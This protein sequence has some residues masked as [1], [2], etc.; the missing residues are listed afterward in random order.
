[1]SLKLVVLSVFC[2]ILVMPAIGYG[3]H[4]TPFHDGDVAP[5]FSVTNLDNETVKLSDWRG[6][7]VM[8]DLWATWCSPCIGAVGVMESEIWQVYKDR[9]VVVWGVD[10]SPER[11]DIDKLKQFREDH[12]LTYP[13]AL[14]VDHETRPYASGYVPTL[15]IIDREGI[16]RFGEVGFGKDAVIAKI[17]ELLNEKPPELTFELKLQKLGT[18]DS[19]T[20]P[21]V[22]APGDAMMLKADVI[23]P[24]LPLPVVAHVALEMFGQFYFW[25]EYGTLM[26]GIPFTL[27][28]QM[29]LLDYQLERVTFNASFP[30]GSFTW[31]GVLAN[32][33]SGEFITEVSMAPWTLAAQMP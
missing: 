25:P 32:P 19:P 14:D 8:M 13:M 4:D 1:M 33:I 11:D 17:E 18:P 6:S 26:T 2:A 22:Y 31:Y 3:Q 24:D 7:I 28:E 30:Q 12:G 15:Y 21:S 27:P 9:G 5:D 29:V 20:D 16:I 23:N 10:I